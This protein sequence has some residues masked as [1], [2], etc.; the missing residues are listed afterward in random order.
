MDTIPLAQAYR[1]LIEAA[2][3]ITPSTSLTEDERAD[4]DWRMAHIALTD[5]LLATAARD[6]LDGSPAI[7]DNLPA[8][9]SDA[10][11]AIIGNTSHAQRVMRV[12]AHGAAFIACLTR[13]SDEQAKTAVRLKLHDRNGALVSD[14]T[15]IWNDLVHV[16]AQRHIPAHVARLVSL[17]IQS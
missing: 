12:R 10:I 15:M 11:A 13:M 7:V 17:S 4:I 1:R 3:A 8:M 16:R 9:D 14:R 6:I 5:E 2:Q